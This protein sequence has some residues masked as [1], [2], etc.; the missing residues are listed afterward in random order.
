VP[1][2]MA[3]DCVGSP[4]RS[5][6]TPKCSAIVSTG[7]R[8]DACQAGPGLTTGY[9]HLVQENLLLLEACS[10]R[11]SAA[12]S[13]VLAG[14]WEAAWLAVAAGPAGA[15]AET[16][17]RRWRCAGAATCMVNIHAHFC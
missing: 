17:S 12:S 16:V 7:R 13:I 9:Q 6:R 3:A 15:C 14:G 10:T 1:A 5:K 8:R 11:S 4:E 2:Y